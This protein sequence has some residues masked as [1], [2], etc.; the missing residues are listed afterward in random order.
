[1]DWIVFVEK[2]VEIFD[3]F[4]KEVAFHP[5]FMGLQYHIVDGG[6]AA[7]KAGMGLEVSNETFPCLKEV[8]IFGC[9]KVFPLGRELLGLG[10][11]EEEDLKG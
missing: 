11:E 8:R 5:I 6:E 9:L 3:G 4:C 2:Q 10:E 7:R 1:M